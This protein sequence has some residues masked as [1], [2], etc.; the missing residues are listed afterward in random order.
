MYE[1]PDGSDTGSQ[2]TSYD[3]YAGLSS[4]DNAKSSFYAKRDNAKSSF[5]SNSQ[6]NRI[7]VRPA[8]VTLGRQQR[9]TQQVKDFIEINSGNTRPR[10]KSRYIGTD[11]SLNTTADFGT[12]KN[13]KTLPSTKEI[14]L[15]EFQQTFSK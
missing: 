2:L 12:E 9:E 6:L 5:L 13:H 14:L 11:N 1:Y 4:R 8:A 10:A 7:S 3:L 15:G